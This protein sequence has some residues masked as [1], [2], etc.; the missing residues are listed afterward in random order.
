MS[1]SA[2][3][4]GKLVLGSIG[5]GGAMVLAVATAL[6]EIPT[7][8]VD[9]HTPMDA[10]VTVLGTYIVMELRAAKKKSVNQAG[11]ET[12]SGEYKSVS[13]LIVS[14]LEDLA[15]GAKENATE[16]KELRLDFA[17]FRGS[18]NARLVGLEGRVD[19]ISDKV[20]NL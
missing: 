2:S 16:V 3:G 20:E 15:F 4:I 8:T 7:P 6:G 18:V 9:S 1:L 19:H 10:L 11:T 5:A 14:K 12:K 17:D 13:D